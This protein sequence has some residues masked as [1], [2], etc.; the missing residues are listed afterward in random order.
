MSGCGQRPPAP[1]EQRAP[2]GARG[3]AAQES[4]R[5]SGASRRP[6]NHEYRCGR[7]SR[8]QAGGPAAGG[9]GPCHRPGWKPPHLLRSHGTC[10]TLAS[11]RGG[12]L[13]C[14]VGNPAVGLGAA[15]PGGPCTHVSTC[16]L[17]RPGTLH[18][19]LSHVRFCKPRRWGAPLCLCTCALAVISRRSERGKLS[20]LMSEVTVA[21]GFQPHHA[22]CGVAGASYPK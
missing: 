5:G 18:Q 15:W 11:R 4:G 17:R 20:P 19:E 3:G 6:R 12:S 8:H 14:R 22:A 10:D 21:A 16:D 2:L 7:W 9:G 1:S 13:V